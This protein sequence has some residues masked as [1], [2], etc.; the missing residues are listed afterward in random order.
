MIA[1]CARW[2]E[3]IM[4]ADVQQPKPVGD[5]LLRSQ[6]NGITRFGPPK[7]VAVMNRFASLD[8]RH[9]KSICPQAPE[10]IDAGGHRAL[11]TRPGHAAFPRQSVDVP[12]ERVQ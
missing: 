12:C 11:S 3:M 9:D 6:D 8:A 1:V 7:L 4:A 10:K 5:G 2:P